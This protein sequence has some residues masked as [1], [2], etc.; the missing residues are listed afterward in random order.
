MGRSFLTPFLA[1][2][3]AIVAATGCM[4]T[5]YFESVDKLD[6]DCVKITAPA[7]LEAVGD[8]ISANVEIRS[9]RSW[10]ASL[11][12]EAG[13]V[14]LSTDHHLNLSGVEESTTLTLSFDE[15]D[16]RESRQVMLSVSTENRKLTIPVIQS[17]F[18]PQLSVST[19]TVF[20]DI[21]F[22]GDT[23]LVCVVANCAWKAAIRPG[24]TAD[25]VPDKSEGFRNDSLYVKVGR[26][27]DTA[28]G[29]TATLVL[30]TP[31]HEDVEIVFNQQKYILNPFL[32]ID[33]S[34][35]RT[36]VPASGGDILVPFS[37]NEMWTAS[38][39]DVRGSGISLSSES[40]SEDDLE[41]TISF[42]EKLNNQG[43]SLDGNSA[44]VVIRTES[45]L[46]DEVTFIQHGC[47]LHSFRRFEAFPETAGWTLTANNLYVA[48]SS[49]KLLIPRYNG[50]RVGKCEY[51]ESCTGVTSSTG[52]LSGEKTHEG[53][54]PEGYRYVFWAG[55]GLSAEDGGMGMLYC[56]AQGLVIGSNKAGLTPLDP[57]YFIE[58]PAIEGKRL[59]RIQI[60]LG[61]SDETKGLKNW[62][63]YA[64]GTSAAIVTADGNAVVSGGELQSAL[65]FDCTVNIPSDFQ[66]EYANHGESMLDF[67][68][69]DT[70]AGASCRIVGPY[71]QVIRWWILYFE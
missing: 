35:K 21:S 56:E 52:A 8:A 40:G 67:I 45:G 71:R 57:A 32:T 61:M 27:A 34:P 24:A 22:E 38:L 42:P 7:S 37:T 2:A 54:S 12:A 30:S 15:Y 6:A 68:L 46:T 65:P 13:W 63:K 16:V 9:N 1:V 14:R 48:K 10:S 25:A 5:N 66:D 18:V 43:A 36:L 28:S 51:V 59:V 69:S 50:G 58:T 3:A 70:S 39:K 33:K 19:P 44:T 17:A 23:L 60:M 49:G 47:L 41:L 11:P 55:P 53:W 29:K 31:G 20:D 62:E 64:T 4:E 26:N